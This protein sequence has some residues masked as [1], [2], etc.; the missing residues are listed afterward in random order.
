MGEWKQHQVYLNIWLRFDGKVR[1]IL[2]SG[3]IKEDFGSLCNGYR[4]I[5]IPGTTKLKRVHRLIADVFIPKTKKDIDLGRDFINH[6]DEDKSNNCVSNL[7]WCTQKENCIHSAHKK[8]GVTIPNMQGSKN[9][10]AR[11]IERYDLQTL[12]TI[13]VYNGGQKEMIVQGFNPG[14]VTSCCQGKLKHYK[15][16]GWRYAD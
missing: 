15:G 6:I 1:R 11:I 13:Q 9:G 10:R 2:K 7:A 12:A 8:R 5:G 14:N 4:V 16:F 3:K